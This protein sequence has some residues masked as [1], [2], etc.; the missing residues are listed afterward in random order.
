MNQT[1]FKTINLPNAVPGAN[2][3][4][5][6][7]GTRV[8]VRVL[9]RNISGTMVFLAAASQDIVGSGGAGS[10]AFRLP[11]GTSE[12]FVLAPDQQLFGAANGV[13]ATV[14]VTV[15]EALPLV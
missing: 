1:L 10:S 15:S 11:P 13:N 12:V 3:T 6:A 4:A 14:S 7:Q 5:I 2:P 8:P 9:V